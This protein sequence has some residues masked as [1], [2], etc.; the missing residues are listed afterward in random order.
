MRILP[1]DMKTGSVFGALG[2]AAS[3]YYIASSE[4]FFALFDGQSMCNLESVRL[5]SVAPQLLAISRKDFTEIFVLPKKRR[6]PF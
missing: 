3:T 2:M 5:Q 1:L 6:L 4:R